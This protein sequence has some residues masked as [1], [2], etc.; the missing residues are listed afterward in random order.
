MVVSIATEVS[1]AAVIASLAS[2]DQPE[3]CLLYAAGA[4]AYKYWL[5][6]KHPFLFIINNDVLVPSGVL[7]KLME[8]MH[9]DGAHTRRISV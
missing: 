3:K 9:D 4:Q 8:G 1:Y 5:Q 2:H 6:G 7:T